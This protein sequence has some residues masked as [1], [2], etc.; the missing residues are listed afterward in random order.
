[1]FR[2]TNGELTNAYDAICHHGYSALIPTPTE[3]RVVGQNWDAIRNGLQSVDLEQYRPH[4]PLRVYAPKSR[5]NLRVV[6]LLHPLDLIIY[7]ALVL[8]AKDEI[9]AARIPSAIRSVFA[10]RANPN[11]PNRLYDPEGSYDSYREELRARS[12]RT[13]GRVVATADIADFYSR[14]YHH[15]LENAL[16]SLATNQRVRNATRILVRRFL[17]GL[18]NGN[19]YGIPVGPLASRLL[20]E[21]LLIDVDEA[22]LGERY[23]CVRWVDDFNIFYRSE[24]EARRALFFLGEWLFD[25]H[26]LTLQPAK[27]STFPASLYRSRVLVDRQ[28][29]LS[30]RISQSKQ[31]YWKALFD[32][33]SAE[34]DYLD[35]SDVTLDDD[36][37]A[38][39]QALEIEKMLERAVSRD[40]VDYEM[41]AFLLGQL[42]ALHAL[43]VDTKI[44]LMNVVLGHVEKIY[45]VAES[46]ARFFV[47]FGDLPPSKKRRVGRALLAPLKA[48][49]HARPPDY[50]VMWVLSIFSASSGWTSAADLLRI[51]QKSQSEVVKRQAAIALSQGATRQQALV[52]R[53]DFGR[54]SPLRQLAILQCVRRLPP[55]ELTHWKRKTVIDGLLEGMM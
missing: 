17:G 3:W 41:A 36:D 40:R 15:R 50:Y 55:D 52:V 8:I 44:K 54:A 27:T 6:T 53:D 21:A 12:T 35:P 32:F 11:R 28:K 2:L 34:T 29:R 33:L 31:Q 18:S 26:G 30:R 45:P 1:M 47:S 42:G 46:I 5:Y 25:K 13:T 49:G 14:I 19:S 16:A 22:L 10:F 7:T 48:G 20:G 43:P 9:E 51:Y 38:Q 37:I 23:R 39:V 4:T 24:A